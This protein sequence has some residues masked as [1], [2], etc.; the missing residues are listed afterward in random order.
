MSSL[1]AREQCPRCRLGRRTCLG[2]ALLVVALAA[3]SSLACGDDDGTD[4]SSPVRDLGM[5]DAVAQPD[6][7]G[8]GETD[9]GPAGDDGGASLPDG[10]ADAGGTAAD[11]GDAGP[12]LDGGDGG[13]APDGGDAGSASDGGDGG[14]AAD[15]GDVELAHDAA[16]ADAG[17]G[18]WEPP[19]D[20]TVCGVEAHAWLPPA[21][22]GRPVTWAP[23]AVGH[24]PAAQIEVLLGEAGYDWVPIEHGVR[25]YNLRYST[26]D[27][28]RVVEATTAV[29]VPDDLPAGEAAPV[30]VWL[31]G[32]SGFTDECA[33][34]ASMEGIVAPALLAAQGYI[35]IAPDYIG[36][37]GFGE[38]SPEGSIMPYLVGEPTALSSID[39]VRAALHALEERRD[40]LPVGDP[41]QVGLLGGSQGGHAAFFF[42]RYL[43]HYAPELSLFGVAAAVPPINL[44]GLWHW[45][46]THAGPATTGLA[47]VLESA[48][49]WYGLPGD[50]HGILTDVAPASLAS[51]LH[52]AMAEGCDAGDLFDGMSGVDDVFAGEFI[53]LSEAQRWDE[54]LP[55]SC[56]LAANS[57][58]GTPV[59][60]G[61]DVPVLATFAE[62]D[63]L[64]VTSVQ[65]PNVE[66]LCGEGYRIE[67]V[68]CAG[69]GHS[70]GGVA[71]LPYVFRWLRER[72]SDEP[73]PE[74]QIC[75]VPEPVD[76]H[77]LR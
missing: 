72:L 1:D 55:L 34:T 12:A 13:A 52:A 26:Q 75:V 61:A 74:A 38:P 76:C 19:F 20:P 6:T 40:E 31:H 36:M 11:G 16:A 14:A 15:A 62:E 57:L 39:A 50:L 70:R 56:L 10:G 22:V 29:G 27:H 3:G 60:R 7:G 65:L 28:G 17:W 58:P 67:T 4:D 42:D 63:N 59:P 77:A 23:M 73:W 18:P 43:P 30:L 53:A 69:D 2:A 48:R 47:G 24:M 33:P 32:T 64:V 41:A 5:R 35:A 45:G 37:N 66:L 49:W 68:R 54:L 9:L 51:N 25:L 8:S 44:L 46:V 71:S 21:R